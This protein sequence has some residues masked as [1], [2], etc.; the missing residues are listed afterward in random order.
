MSDD[1]RTGKQ[2]AWGVIT[3]TR[4][5]ALNSLTTE[6]CLA[7]D[8]ALAAWAQDESVKAVLVEGEGE[9]AF[10]AGGDIRWLYKKGQEDPEDA[11]NFFR[12]EYRMNT[13]IAKFPKPYVALIDGI[14][15]GGGVGI[16]QSGTHRIATERTVW[17]MPEC[18]IGLFTD[19]GTSYMLPRLPDGIGNYLAFTGTR[20]EGADCLTAEVAT[21]VVPSEALPALRA[22]LL[23]LGDDGEFAMAISHLVGEVASSRPGDIVEMLGAIREYFGTVESLPALM[24]ALNREKDGFG[25]YCLDRIGRGSP[26]SL[27]INHKLLAEAPDTFEACIAREFNVAANILW[28]HDF[29]EGVRAQ[30]IDKD[31]RPKWS[32]ARLADVDPAEIDRYFGVPTG[33]PLDLSD[34]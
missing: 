21:H 22:A 33:G 13:R 18:A 19:V 10:C 14:C 29:Y 3:L 16:S 31:H 4:P 28:G 25:G 15:M 1:I 11:G 12:A 9:R 5:Q 24:S 23:G 8:Q 32:P 27:L 26:T 30:V 2:G 17:A 20:L 6:M 7:I 34:I